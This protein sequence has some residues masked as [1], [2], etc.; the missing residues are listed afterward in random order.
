[1][2]KSEVGN[3]EIRIHSLGWRGVAASSPCSSAA[4]LRTGVGSLPSEAAPVPAP[5]AG[6]ELRGALELEVGRPTI[7]PGARGGGG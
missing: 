1:M 3:A 7:A 6:L 4:G 2:P 5:G